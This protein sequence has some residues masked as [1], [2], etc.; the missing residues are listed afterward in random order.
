MTGA[1]NRVPSILICFLYFSSDFQETE[2]REDR[3]G[4]QSLCVQ[5]GARTGFQMHEVAR[6]TGCDAALP[7][8]QQ[9]SLAKYKCK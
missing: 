2:E 6:S 1:A 5:T 4:G 7:N 3:V 8:I 9:P